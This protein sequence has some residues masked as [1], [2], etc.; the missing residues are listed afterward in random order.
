MVSATWNRTSNWRRVAGRDARL[1]ERLRHAFG[2]SPYGPVT[3]DAVTAKKAL[4]V[5]TGTEVRE[6][7]GGLPACTCTLGVARS[8]SDA[9]QY[10]DLHLAYA[11]LDQEHDRRIYTCAQT[12]RHWQLVYRGSYYPDADLSPLSDLDA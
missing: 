10:A 6:G 9:E 11:A 8:G 3:R 5:A 4:E 1:A 7:R 2:T 12:G